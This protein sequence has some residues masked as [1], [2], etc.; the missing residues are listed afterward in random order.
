LYRLEELAP[1]FFGRVGQY[2][3]ILSHKNVSYHDR[4]GE[5]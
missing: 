4:K 5:K 1:H 3:M 2:P